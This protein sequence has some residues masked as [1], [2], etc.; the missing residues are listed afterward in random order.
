MPAETDKN[1]L[2]NLKYNNTKYIIMRDKVEKWLYYALFASA[3]AVAFRNAAKKL[4][5]G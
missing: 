2:Q 3:G 4:R 5:N 1:A